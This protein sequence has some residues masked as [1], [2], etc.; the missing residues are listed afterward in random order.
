MAAKTRVDLEH[1]LRGQD[2]VAE[3]D[4]GGDEFAGDGADERERDRDLHAGEDRRQGGGKPDLP[5]DLER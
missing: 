1:A 3:P 2:D 5:Q 4:L